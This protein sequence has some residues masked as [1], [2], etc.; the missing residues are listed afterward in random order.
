MPERRKRKQVSGQESQNERT[1][2]EIGVGRRK[3]ENRMKKSEAKAKESK[4]EE[5]TKQ[6]KT[7][8]KV[9]GKKAEFRRNKTDM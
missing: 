1:R 2:R 4:Q 6:V 3:G 9:E 8:T 5:R 7:E